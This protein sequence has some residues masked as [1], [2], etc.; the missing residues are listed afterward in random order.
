MDENIRKLFGVSYDELLEDSLL[1]SIFNSDGSLA[2]INNKLYLWI[3]DWRLSRGL[4]SNNSWILS[5]C[6]CLFIK[7][8]EFKFLKQN[9]PSGFYEEILFDNCSWLRC[10]VLVALLEK[11]VNLDWCSYS[12]GIY[13]PLFDELVLG[14]NDSKVKLMLSDL[15][16]MYLI[17]QNFEKALETF[18]ISGYSLFRNYEDSHIA[19]VADYLDQNCKVAYLGGTGIGDDF[20]YQI[21]EYL[22][23][24]TKHQKDDLDGDAILV[25]QDE[26]KFVMNI[27]YSGKIRLMNAGCLFFIRQI[28]G[29]EKFEDYKKY[30]ENRF[31]EGKVTFYSFKGKYDSESEI[32]L[33]YVSPESALRGDDDVHSNI[34]FPAFNEREIFNRQQEFISEYGNTNLL[35][36]RA[37]SGSSL[38]VEDED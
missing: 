25:S 11:G 15:C 23:N 3:Y 17:T 20:L 36:V 18:N 1:L 21:L 4:E 10:D 37:S 19:R 32:L 34:Y 9:K 38:S 31:L 29:E 7:Y 5:A 26:L 35:L 13:R 30:L 6:D 2:T 33:G 12:Y 14:V 28:L 27:I 22:F 24:K 16:K 8:L